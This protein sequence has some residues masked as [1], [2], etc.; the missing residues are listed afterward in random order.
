MASDRPCVASSRACRP[1]LGCRLH[2]SILLCRV[3]IFPQDPMNAPRVSNCMASKA[4]RG[5]LPRPGCERPRAGGVSGREF[6]H[7][8]EWD[9]TA[10]NGPGTAPATGFSKV[11]VAWGLKPRRPRADGRGAHD[12]AAARGRL[13]RSQRS[14]HSATGIPQ[15]VLGRGSSDSGRRVAQ[16]SIRNRHSVGSGGMLAG[17]DTATRKK[18]SMLPIEVSSSATAHRSNPPRK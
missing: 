11:P 10:C 18:R 3:E 2:L 6:Q 5:D 17:S 9:A 8:P 14:S 4:S 15:E 1:F 12:L 7:T 13:P 16:S